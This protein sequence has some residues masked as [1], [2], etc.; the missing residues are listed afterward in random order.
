MEREKGSGKMAFLEVKNLTRIYGKKE[1][2]LVALDHV[3][4]AVDKGSLSR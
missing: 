1:N 2:A 3:S 4:F